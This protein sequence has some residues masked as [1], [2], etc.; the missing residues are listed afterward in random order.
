M[1][2]PWS[3]RGRRTWSWYIRVNGIPEYELQMGD[4]RGL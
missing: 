1:Q 3:Y 4:P 2:A